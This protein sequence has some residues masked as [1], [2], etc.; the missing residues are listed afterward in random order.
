M[1]VG[2]FKGL[3]G[4][5]CAGQGFKQLGSKSIDLLL[6][7]CLVHANA[8]CQ[9]GGSENCGSAM[10]TLSPPIPVAIRDT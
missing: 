2:G 8:D 10:L 4:R 9:L 5:G 1:G 7:Q 3:G 6:N